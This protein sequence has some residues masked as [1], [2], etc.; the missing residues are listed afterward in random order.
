MLWYG[1][2]PSQATIVGIAYHEPGKYQRDEEH[3]AG[4]KVGSNGRALLHIQTDHRHRR[5]TERYRWFI[6]LQYPEAYLFYQPYSQ[7]ANAESYDDCY[8]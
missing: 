4:E 7:N 2:D 5:V 3:G 6:E 8:P 1:H